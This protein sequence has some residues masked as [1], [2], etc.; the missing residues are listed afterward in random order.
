MYVCRGIWDFEKLVSFFIRYIRYVI[1]KWARSINM[2]E[3]KPAKADLTLKLLNRIVEML[4][5]E[6]SDD[7]NPSNNT[8]MQNGISI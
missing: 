8:F 4:H 7:N 3:K 2:W 5:I 6:I 1:K